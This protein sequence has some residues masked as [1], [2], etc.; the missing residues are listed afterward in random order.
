MATF[1]TS[2]TDPLLETLTS[3]AAQQRTDFPNTHVPNPASL[4]TTSTPKTITV[5]SGLSLF[6][7]ALL[8]AL[9]S[10]RREIIFVT[11]F[12]A[13]SDSLAALHA[14]LTRL[15]SSRTRSSPELCVFIGFSSRSA[16]QKLFHTSSRDGHVV[17]PGKWEGMGLPGKEALEAGNIRLE[18]KSLFFTPSS[19][20]HPKFVV[21]DRRWACVPS[22]NVSWEVWFEGCIGFEGAAVGVLVDFWRA[23]WKKDG[24]GDVGVD[25]GVVDVG[26]CKG[27]VDAGVERGEGAHPERHV[28]LQGKTYPTMVLPSSHHRNPRFRLPFCKPA[29]PPVTPLNAALLTLFSV[30]QRDISII[31][32]NITCPA[33]LDAL[34]AALERGVN[35]TIRTSRKMM[36]LEQLVTAFTI[37]EW[38]VNSLIK[39]YKRLK[40]PPAGF[41]GELSKGWRA[42]GHVL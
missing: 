19:V 41:G 20:M 38:S 25:D 31:T 40:N 39:R 8:P 18:V 36:L 24:W 10:A 33:V 11:C 42:Y 37:N 29:P 28:L 32:P 7:N 1:P 34:L 30:A 5:G 21:V 13:K 27:V 9:L 2:F 14:A 6:T 26:V 35:V 23:V 12:W 16:L 22:C 15:L 4:I 17:P 3:H